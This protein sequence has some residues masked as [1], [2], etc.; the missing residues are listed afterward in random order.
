MNPSRRAF[1]K[2][3][4]G[5]LVTVGLSGRLRS[6]TNA[7]PRQFHPTDASAKYKCILNHELLIIS[8][9][10]DNSPAYIGSFIDKLKDTDVDAIMCCPTM[11]RTNLYPSEVDPQWK[12]YGAEQ[13][14]SKFPSFDK[15]MNYIHGGGDPVKD[16]L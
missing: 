13:K 2:L 5:A 1:L 7:S 12:K 8:G 14:S 6:Q 11:W 15:M 16:T 10:K 4:S 9:K 3:S